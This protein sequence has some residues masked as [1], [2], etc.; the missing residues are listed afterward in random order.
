MPKPRHIKAF[1]DRMGLA[2]VFAGMNNQMGIFLTYQ[3]RAIIG[4][5]VNNNML[6]VGIILNQHALDAIFDPFDTVQDWG[7][8]AYKREFRQNLFV[9]TECVI[10]LSL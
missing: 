8:N 6:N 10:Y 7:D 1:V 2:A 5:S 3:K 4:A 9:Y